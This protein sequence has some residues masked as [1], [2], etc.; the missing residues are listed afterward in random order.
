MLQRLP[1]ELRER[2]LQSSERLRKPACPLGPNDARWT[3]I[4]QERVLSQTPSF[5]HIVM[6]IYRDVLNP[7]SNTHLL[8]YQIR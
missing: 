3:R 8:F 1:D 2:P 7:E 5:G 4:L 6:K